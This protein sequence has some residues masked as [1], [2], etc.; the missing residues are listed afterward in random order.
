MAPTAAKEAGMKSTTARR[1][2]SLSTCRSSRNL[3]A[4]DS[5]DDS[6]L[7]GEGSGQMVF[8]GCGGCCV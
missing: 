6:G 1:T 8:I 3:R 5:S 4:T 7:Q 2:S